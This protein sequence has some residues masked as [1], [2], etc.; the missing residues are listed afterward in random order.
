VIEGA[1]SNPFARGQDGARSTA[2]LIGSTVEVP[3]A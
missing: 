1:A 2:P 3:R